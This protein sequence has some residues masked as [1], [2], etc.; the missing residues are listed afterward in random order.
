MGVYIKGK[1]PKGCYDCSCF[2]RNSDGSDY[3]CLLMLDIK[4]N[5]KRDDNCPLIE[6]PLLTTSMPHLNISSPILDPEWQ[7]AHKAMGFWSPL[8]D[9]YEELGIISAEEDE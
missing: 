2:I 7:K 3:C 1:M 5:G 6:L 9:L 4:D 8:A